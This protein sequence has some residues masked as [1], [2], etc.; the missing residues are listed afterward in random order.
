MVASKNPPGPRFP[1]I[2]FAAVFCDPLGTL[3][4]MVRDYGDVVHLELHGRHHFLL[5][6]PDFIRAILLDQDG[7]RRSIQP[8]LKRLLGKGLLSSEYKFHQRQRRLIQPAFHKERIAALG[9]A[10]I[11]KSAR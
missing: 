7:M 10:I 11:S 5:N 3:K 6:H 2:T 1:W 9:E 4:R 8:P